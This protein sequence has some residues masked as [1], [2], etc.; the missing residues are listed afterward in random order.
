M[1]AL[2]ID[3]TRSNLLI[4]LVDGDKSYKKLLCEGNK[5]HNSL[6][7]PT[8]EELLCEH[9]LSLSD[10]DF[11]GVVI[12]PGSFTGIR[13]GV[14]TINALAFATK[15]PV[16]GVTAFELIAYN[17]ECG[18]CLVNALHENFYGATF[19]TG[20]IL[21]MEFWEKDQAPTVN[22]FYQEADDDYFEN[23]VELLKQKAEDENFS[24]RAM[25]LYLRK[26]QAERE[27]D[28]DD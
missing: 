12:G 18:A 19:K 3:S 25:P 9:C 7:L 10:M 28:G 14:A 24:F 26:S 6:L 2:G 1:R 16:I 8:I 27:A 15:K 21:K 22:V 5:R 11:F 13:I 17:K 23:Y 4:I 20:K